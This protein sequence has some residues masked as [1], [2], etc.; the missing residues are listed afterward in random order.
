VHACVCVRA[1]PWVCRGGRG[2]LIVIIIIIII[3][4]PAGVNPHDGRGNERLNLTRQRL[5]SRRGHDGGGAAGHDL[6]MGRKEG[7]AWREKRPSMQTPVRVG[8]W[9]MGFADEPS[10]ASRTWGDNL[11]VYLRNRHVDE[12]YE[13]NLSP[14]SSPAPTPHLPIACKG[15]HWRAEGGLKVCTSLTA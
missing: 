5:V 11:Y 1:R 2:C 7:G 8:G 12:H 9:R 13:G 3:Y 6:R 14:R 10:H 4:L 15:L